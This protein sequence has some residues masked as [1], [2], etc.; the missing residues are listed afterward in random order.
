MPRSGRITARSLTIATC[1]LFQ[2]RRDTSVQDSPVRRSAYGPRR[3]S[4]EREGT[5]LP[6]GRRR[7]AGERSHPKRSSVESAFISKGVTQRPLKSP[8]CAISDQ[9]LVEMKRWHRSR[10]RDRWHTGSCRKL[11]HGTA[12]VSLCEYWKVHLVQ[13]EPG[14]MDEINPPRRAPHPAVRP[15]DRRL[16]RDRRRRSRPARDPVPLP[17][18]LPDTTTT[19]AKGSVSSTVIVALRCVHR[20]VGIRQD[21][22]RMKHS[23]VARHSPGRSRVHCESRSEREACWR[24]RPPLWPISWPFVTLTPSLTARLL[25]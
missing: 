23:P 10:R 20:L 13:V 5:D 14:R 21:V 25:R 7:P 1:P 8:H 16:R 2:I 3:R 4:A 12:L 11:D 17:A 9:S 19:G 22:Q 18:R 24:R 6:S 15:P